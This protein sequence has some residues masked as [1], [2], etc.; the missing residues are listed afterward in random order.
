MEF[1]YILQSHQ[2]KSVSFC[3]TL[4]SLFYHDDFKIMIIRKILALPC[5]PSEH[6]R[7][8]FDGVRAKAQGEQ[9][10]SIT[11]KTIDY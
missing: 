10:S 2:T 7:H 8:A 5:L 11:L 6:I 4:E 1:R 9:A 3:F